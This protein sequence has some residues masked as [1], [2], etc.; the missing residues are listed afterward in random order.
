MFCVRECMHICTG[1]RE[2]SERRTNRNFWVLIGIRYRLLYRADI[3]VN[4]ISVSTQSR[5]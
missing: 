3:K 5:L 2:K 4:Q 1:V